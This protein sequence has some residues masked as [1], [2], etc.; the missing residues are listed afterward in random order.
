MIVLKRHFIPLL[1][2]VLGCSVFIYILGYKR[3]R[4]HDSAL[5]GQASR[6]VSV[7]HD[8]TAEAKIQNAILK[9]FL[10]LLGSSELSNSTHKY[11]PYNFLP[12]AG[13]PIMAIGNAGHQSLL[14]MTALMPYF[15]SLENKK[16]VVLISPTWFNEYANGT[17]PDNFSKYVSLDKLYRIYQNNYLPDEFKF[18]LG[19]YLRENK[20]HFGNFN[21]IISAFCSKVE[22]N[23]Q[24]YNPVNATCYA[25]LNA[26]C[27]WSAI[28]KE[29]SRDYYEYKPLPVL[30][31]Y[32][33]TKL[34]QQQ[35]DTF[36]KQCTNN[37][38]YVTN[39]YYSKYI[40]N[41][42]VKQPE[43]FSFENSREWSDFLCML[44]FFKSAKAKVYF[45]MQ[46]LNPHFYTAIDVYKDIV[47]Q[48]EKETKKRNLPLLNMF[49]FN[50]KKYI[51][52]TLCDI[53][54]IGELGWLKIDSA[55]IQHY[56]K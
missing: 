38:Y 4:F 53:M 21:S 37:T 18:A 20:H 5:N 29:R 7:A 27:R 48:I 44:D 33:W 8:S 47:N 9:D 56:G 14:I 31:H 2:A 50:K 1:V 54:H 23:Q 45:I 3:H 52:G 51:P 39:D 30:Q 28:D 24:P 12:K 11:I 55:L 16:I 41:V 42:D 36:L 19:D 35:R 25:F 17:H 46:P 6:L 13:I 49:A 26:Y 32:N 43:P 22:F 10:I 15:E 40:K 34:I